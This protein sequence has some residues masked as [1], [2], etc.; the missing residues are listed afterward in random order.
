M[1]ITSMNND[2]LLSALT[3][4]AEEARIYPPAFECPHYRECN[5]SV[6]GSLEGGDGCL[7]SYVGRTYG[8][9]SGGGTSF[10]LVIVGIDH[11]DQGGGTFEYRTQGIQD[12]YQRGRH[13]FNP[14]Y[15]GVIKTATAVFGMAGEF[16]INNCTRTCGKTLSAQ[17][18]ECVLDRI[19]QPNSVKCTP[20]DQVGRTSTATFT[21]KKNCSYHLASEL[22]VLRPDLVVF[23]GAHARYFILPT[24]NTSGLNLYPVDKAGADS[25][26]PVLYR[27]DALNAHVLFLYHPTYGGLDRQWRRLSYLPCPTYEA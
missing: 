15:R 11:G 13:S 8:A 3:S 20:H 7:M 2:H 6:G 17:A 19:V 4:W 10:R 18:T 14:H 22:K 26:G 1:T 12:W 27:S 9:A 21:M 25:H 5:S 23:H 24:F 16:C